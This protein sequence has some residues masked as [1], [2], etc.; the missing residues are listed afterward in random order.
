MWKHTRKEKNNL[1]RKYLE[2]V[3]S[4]T[5]MKLSGEKKNTQ[6]GE[7]TRKQYS[8][9][10]ILYYPEETILTGKIYWTKKE[11]KYIG[12]DKYSHCELLSWEKNRD[13][14]NNRNVKIL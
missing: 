7:D 12:N 9:R 14:R 2:W 11:R 6:Q 3:K 13:E 5:G 1:Q 10:E 8:I 4:F